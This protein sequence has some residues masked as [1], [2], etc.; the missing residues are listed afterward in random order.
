[1]MATVNIQ[2][3]LSD[4]EVAY[5]AITAYEQGVGYWAVGRR[6]E[7]EL[8]GRIADG[9]APECFVLDDDTALFELRDRED[10]TEPWMRVTP[11][12]IAR[13]IGLY[14]VGANYP[15]DDPNPRL[16]GTVN[17]MGRHFDDM[18]DLGAMDAN[19]ADCVVQL[20]LFGR[21]VYG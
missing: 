3:T 1:M 15:D 7:G 17:F 5:I 21:L 10:Q 18:E 9:D 16:R 4:S 19:E 14:L 12:V 6:Y 11:A 8:L 13:G 20:G 2:R